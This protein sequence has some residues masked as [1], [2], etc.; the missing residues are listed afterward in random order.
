VKRGI[1]QS[2]ISVALM[3]AVSGCIPVDP[4][5]YDPTPEEDTGMRLAE[6]QSI[7]QK[8]E[9]EVAATI[10][11]PLVSAIEQQDQGSLLSCSG[12]GSHWAGHTEI[13]F[14]GP[15]DASRIFEAAAS[16]WSSLEGW[17]AEVD[18]TEDGA[19]QFVL[20][21]P[22]RSMYL[23]TMSP[24]GRSAHISSASPCVEVLP[25]EEQRRTY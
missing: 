13:S 12:G 24:D 5:R 18:E 14:A 23:M 21:G 3:L 8:T 11:A 20:R 22:G 17:R 19:P 9:L 1:L 15:I 4:D 10:P 25:G 16:Q 2:V 6:A 7:T